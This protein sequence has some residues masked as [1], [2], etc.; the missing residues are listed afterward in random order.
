MSKIREKAAGLLAAK[1]LLRDEHHKAA[2]Q[3]AV[4]NRKSRRLLQ[5]RK[6]AEIAAADALVAGQLPDNVDLSRRKLAKLMIESSGL[7]GVLSRPETA[8]LELMLSHRLKTGHTGAKAR[9]AYW[10]SLGDPPDCEPGDHEAA[11][12]F[13]R[14]ILRTLDQGGWTRSERS[15][16]YMMERRWRRRMDG[17]D[18]RFEEAGTTGAGRL[19]RHV[20]KRIDARRR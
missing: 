16:L 1:T 14:Q 17:L 15:A 4:R 10:S 9:A 3:K 11:R 2:V 12:L 20:E 19:P 8:D 5:R 18:P 7:A 6:Q 13:H